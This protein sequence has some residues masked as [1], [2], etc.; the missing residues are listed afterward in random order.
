MPLTNPKCAE[1]HAFAFG[2]F[3]LGLAIFLSLCFWGQGTSNLSAAEPGDVIKPAPSRAAIGAAIEA[4]NA[5][6][7]ND[8]PRY[9]VRGYVIEGNTLLATNTLTPIFAWHTGTNVGLE[10]I[11]QAAFDLQSAYRDQGYP[12]MCIAIGKLE[13]P[14]GIVTFHVYK[15]AF[16]QILVSGKCYLSPGSDLEIL[17]S[18]TATNAFPN[19]ALTPDKNNN[20]AASTNS[21]RQFP[22]LTYQ[23]AG[24]SLLP[25][26]VFRTIFL[27]YTGTNITFT[28]ITKA[29]KELQMEYH[30]RGFDTVSVTIPQQ[31]LTNAT[32]KI[33]VFEGRLAEIMVSGNH[34]YSSNNIMH[35]L[36][37]LN[38]NMFLNSKLFQSELDR[39][40]ANQDRQIYPE[41][42]PGPDTNTTSLVLKVK[43][44]F[45]LHGKVELNNQSSPGTPDLRLNASAVYNNLWQLDHSLGVQYS[46]SPENYKVG[47][48]WN[49]YD[50][51]LVANYSAFYRMPLGGPEPMADLLASQPGSFG[52]NEAT[53]KF[54]LPPAS[55][56]PELNLY[57]SR[58]TIDTG[59]QSGAS[60]RLATSI[61]GTIDQIG[62]TQDL[63]VNEG[64]GFRLSE[65]LPIVEGINSRVQAGLDF[66]SYRISSFATNYF[67]FT[68]YLLDTA[69]NPFTRVSVTPSP[70]PGTI[71]TLTYLPL[72]LRWDGSRPDKYGGMAFGIGYTPNLW[73]SKGRQN[74]Q[75]IAG[76]AEAS[77]YYHTVTANL[78]R[79][80][81]LPGGWKLSLRADGQWANQP[82]ISNEQFGVGGIGGVRG[83]REGEVFGDTGWRLTSE[84]T[85]PPNIIGQ[86]GEGKARPLT[87]RGSF[88]MDYAETYLLDPLGRP[89]STPLWGTGFGAVA[90]IG[91]NF[92][93]RLLFAWPLLR[94]SFSEPGQIRIYFGVGAQ[95]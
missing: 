65:P 48:Q 47:D 56:I 46:F 12:A 3:R 4:A 85:T 68:Q 78:A 18:S 63:T 23:I 26:E 43:D 5:A 60:K 70:V 66:K 28:D 69:G 14:N 33:Q 80:Q 34:Y 45:P 29:A 13:F 9:D 8:P 32:F 35:A 87:V 2:I 36:P 6:Y 42:R 16:S 51:P 24:N 77:G 53:R 59:V 30:D 1:R 40:N 62:D 19:A 31:R 50:R 27:K 15:G 83:Y 37:G 44:R 84:L 92:E 39:A 10:E 20:A 55:G 86:V 73:Y 64:L 67:I 93:A 91:P 71:R 58:S 88:F 57:A 76:S 82:L 52:Y 22:I 17:A 81:R 90:A 72:S 95:F 79:E 75:E 89:G 49:F 61:S 21:E 54:E 7:P 74:L 25:W 94:T 38:T 41:I 11:V